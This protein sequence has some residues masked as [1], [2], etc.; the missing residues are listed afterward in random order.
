[1]ASECCRQIVG[2][3]CQTGGE[4]A[5]LN[6]P[7]RLNVCSHL[8]RWSSACIHIYLLQ[9]SMLVRYCKSGR[10]THMRSPSIGPK[11]VEPPPRRAGRWDRGVCRPSFAAPHG[12]AGWQAGLLEEMQAS[13]VHH[14][15]KQ[16]LPGPTARISCL[17]VRWRLPG[18][19]GAGWQTS[20][21]RRHANKLLA[22]CCFGR[23]TVVGW[24]RRAR[25]PSMLHLLQLSMV[26]LDFCLTAISIATT[27]LSTRRVC[28]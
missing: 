8:P 4:R 15:S 6:T 14:R 18:A 11:I 26:P 3:D 21:P 23:A 25:G 13:P 2:G 1:M 16:P 17:R 24:R 12:L 5:V 20:P 9:Q 7:T 19:C 10:R 28:A 22:A 27:P